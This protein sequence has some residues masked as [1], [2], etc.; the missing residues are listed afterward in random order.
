MSIGQGH[1]SIFPEGIKKDIKLETF[2]T[3]IKRYRA[4]T[5]YHSPRPLPQIENKGKQ[6]DKE[7]TKLPYSGLSI[8]YMKLNQRSKK[9]NITSDAPLNYSHFFSDMYFNSETISYPKVEKSDAFQEPIDHRDFFLPIK[10]NFRRL[11]RRIWTDVKNKE[12][13]MCGINNYTSR[14]AGKGY[15]FNYKKKELL[16][17]T[18]YKAKEEQAISNGLKIKGILKAFKN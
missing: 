14:S 16:P 5:T 11:K 3:R 13:E 1:Q 17:M 15:D 4:S 2:Q 12:E 7:S 8:G 6:L 9:N 10:V 18:R